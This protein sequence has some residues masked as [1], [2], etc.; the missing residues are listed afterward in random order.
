MTEGPGRQITDPRWR[1][2]AKELVLAMLAPRHPAVAPLPQA[3]RTTLHLTSCAGRLDELTRFCQWLSGHGV[4]SLAQIDTH[5]CDAYMAH[6]RYV[7]DEHGVVV[8]EQSPGTRRTAAQVVVD[9]VNDRELFTAE[10]VPADL[11]P[12]GAW[13]R[14]SGRSSR[15]TGSSPATTTSST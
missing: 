9:L 7:L 3:H 5:V 13:W 2:V 15:P 6:R 4:S 12:W 11:R 10:R 1:L 14:W 8:G